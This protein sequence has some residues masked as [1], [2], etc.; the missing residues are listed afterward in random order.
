L[1]RA[2]WALIAILLVSILLVSCGGG[3]TNPATGTT[4]GITKRAFISNQFNAAV[5]IVNAATDQLSTHRIIIDANPT[6]MTLSPDRKTT[7]AF[8]SGA[9]RLDVISNSS[10]IQGG[11]LQLAE[12]TESFF[13]LPDN[14]TVMVAVRNSGVVIT[15]DTTAGAT[16]A[17]PAPNAR[18]IVQSPDGK[19]VLAFADDSS[20]KV[21]IIDTTASPPT[22]SNVAGF[23]RPVWAV[24]SSDGSK[25]YV[26][27]C[28]PECGG[29][30]AGVQVL[31]LPAK[32]LG[33]LQAVP[34]ATH[35]LLNGTTLYVAGTPPGTPCLNNVNQSRCGSISTVDVSSGLGAVA[36]FEI[37]NGYHDHMLLGPNNKL[38]VGAEFT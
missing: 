19:T 10:E 6:V 3:Y 17:I 12:A 32:T 2:A 26:M 18:W 8:A 28:G 16:I 22:V 14:R 34:G 37:N 35:G 9:N 13:Y 11:S 1:Q 30:A 7:L 5:D 21:Y 36:S 33:A 20:N 24:F 38:F 23:D 25:A 4:S 29:T 31:N 27:N 15:W